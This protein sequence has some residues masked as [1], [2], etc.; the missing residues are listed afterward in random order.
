MNIVFVVYAF[1]LGT[2]MDIGRTMG[3][4]E[5]AAVHQYILGSTQPVTTDV[6]VK[7]AKKAKHS[8]QE[9]PSE[10]PGPARELAVQDGVD[11]S[12]LQHASSGEYRLLASVG[13]ET[14]LFAERPIRTAQTVPT[15]A[16]VKK[17]EELFAS[18]NPNAAITF[19]DNTG[20]LIVVLSRPKIAVKSS[21]GSTVRIEYTMTQSDSQGDVVSIEQFV[22]MSGG[23]GSCSLFI[24][25]IRE[26]LLAR[27]RYDF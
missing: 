19:A 16:F 21:E 14:V 10:P 6:A 7:S 18:S 17:F 2:A 22:E 20:P 3:T 13:T 11:C 5:A 12:I 15:Q 1:L 23:S 4:A 9:Q 26:V 27:S 24:D 25:S 8:P